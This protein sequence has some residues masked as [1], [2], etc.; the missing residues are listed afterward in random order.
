MT[1]S[2]AIP[3]LPLRGGALFPGAVSSFSVGRAAS[4]DLAR[5]LAPGDVILTVSQ[6]DARVSAPTEDELYRAGTYARVRSIAKKGSREL[7]V[8]L[9]PERL[10]S[11]GH[12][13]RHGRGRVMGEA[14]LLPSR[15]RVGERREGMPRPRHRAAPA[16]CRPGWW[17]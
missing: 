3:T 17:R 12:R 6:K 10:A 11:V 5:Q 8:V 4:L 14:A 15:E 13:A 9:D 7:Q 1:M 16:Q 2:S